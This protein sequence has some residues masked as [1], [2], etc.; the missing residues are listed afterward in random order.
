M[1]TRQLA[2]ALGS[3]GLLAACGGTSSSP[4]PSPEGSPS[5]TT[6]SSATTTPT[7]TPTPE[8][9]RCSAVLAGLSTEQK[10]G[11]LLVMGVDSNSSGADAAAVIDELHIGA[12]I[13]MGNTDRGVAGIRELTDAL[14]TGD[15]PVQVMVSTDHEGGL[16]QRLKGPGFTEIPNAV[17]QAD[18]GPDGLRSEATAWAQELHEAGVDVDLAPVADVVPEKFA[19]DNEPVAQVKRGYGSDPAT[20]GALVSAFVEGMRDGGVATAVKH[21]PG[22]GQVAG[23]TDFH[24]EVV[25]ETTTAEDP[26][27]ASFTAA[28]DAD[29]P[30]VMISSARYVKIDPEEI[31]MFS[32]VVIQQ[33]LRDALG[34]DGVVVSDDVGVAKAVG[35]VEVADRAISFLTAGGDLVI[36]VDPGSIREMQA[37]VLAKAESDPAFAEQVDASALRVLQ[38]KESLGR[39]DCG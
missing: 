9:P 10:V 30:M 21:F 13:L 27:L 39:V 32:P 16:V 7:S 28:I 1:R 4:S 24:D 22:L 3:L 19:A 20:V 38:L 31:A 37:G 35:H 12:V 23:N 36:N 8:E 18:L 17:D 5:V 34:Y 14:R 29:V 6:T 26:T 2:A 25:D 11:Q 15:G 33:L